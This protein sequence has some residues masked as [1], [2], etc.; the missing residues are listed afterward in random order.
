MMETENR[1]AVASPL[2]VDLRCAVREENPVWHLAWLRR[3]RHL[4][5]HG[6]AV[7]AQQVLAEHLL[8]RRPRQRVPSA[9]NSSSRPADR[10]PLEPQLLLPYSPCPDSALREIRSP[11]TQRRGILTATPPHLLPSLPSSHRPVPACQLLAAL[12]YRSA[13][14][15]QKRLRYWGCRSV[16][17]PPIDSPHWRHESCRA[18]APSWSLTAALAQWSSPT[19]TGA[20][21][22]LA[23]TAVSAA[24]RPVRHTAPRA[25]NAASALWRHLDHATTPQFCGPPDA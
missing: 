2:E 1:H 12:R 15:R 10:R 5:F 16:V 3:W 25:A 4:G 21:T 8:V 13:Y 19:P 24:V 20:R 7:T 17:A 23:T 22:A 6:R 11:Q 18:M 9:A 14:H